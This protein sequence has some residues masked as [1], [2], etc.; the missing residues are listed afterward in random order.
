MAFDSR[1]APL[2]LVVE[3]DARVRG[4][5]VSLL[6]GAGYRCR[7]AGTGQTALEAIKKEPPSLVLLDL[8]LPDFRGDELVTRIVQGVPGLP[9]V[10]L[11]V[12]TD[13]ESI[14]SALR[15]GAVGYLFKEDVGRLLPA[16]EDAFAGGAPMSPAVARLVLA[17]LRD[18][19][20]PP[21]P[22]GV[23]SPREREVLEVMAGG[24]S[25]EQAA[26]TL[27]LTVNTIRS[28][29]KN[30]YRK[31]DAGTRLEAVLAALRRGELSSSLAAN[32]NAAPGRPEPPR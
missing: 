19:V 5:I 27:D 21:A 25:Y 13:D 4:F 32:P 8:G 12:V 14:V 1:N 22:E 2:V 29:V 16:L 7:G 15:A 28:H 24:L 30:I 9:V 18:D 31:L 6:E 26:L 10:V 17:K 3:D 11:S 20:P 23:L